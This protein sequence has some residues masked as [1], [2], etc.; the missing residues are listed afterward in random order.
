MLPVAIPIDALVYIRCCNYASLRP[1][2]PGKLL[3]DLDVS[4]THRHEME[5]DLAPAGPSDYFVA[6]DVCPLGIKLL[7]M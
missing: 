3:V 6:P 7:E 1:R 4:V 2:Y 5:G